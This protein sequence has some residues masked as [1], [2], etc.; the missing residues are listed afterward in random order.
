[1]KRAGCCPDIGGIQ[2][3]R[4]VWLTLVVVGC[5]SSAQSGEHPGSMDVV[6]TT[7]GPQQTMDLTRD[8]THY[9]TEYDIS[10]DRVLRALLAAQDDI[11]IPLH[12]SDPTTGTV[13]HLSEP[14]TSRIAGKPA[15]TWVDCGRGAG[16]TPRASTHRITL[17]VTSV[18]DSLAGNR[19]RLRVMLVGSAR[20]RG[21]SADELQ[22]ATTGQFEKHVL[23]VVFARLAS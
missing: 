11:G 20:D 14:S 10:R 15:W 9:T 2:M 12:A 23:A 13:V 1:M 18:V 6:R 21:L 5:A 22:C 7:I 19:S 17:R 3:R 16:G 4:H 8:N